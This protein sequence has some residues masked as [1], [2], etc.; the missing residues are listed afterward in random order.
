MFAADDLPP[1]RRREFRGVLHDEGHHP[2]RLGGRQVGAP[3]E[4]ARDQ[5]EAR[6]V[7][8]VGVDLHEGQDVARRRL[9][10]GERLRGGGGLHQHPLRA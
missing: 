5:G 3:V 2:Q 10:V 7:P 4:P 9:L 6:Q 1:E 8:L